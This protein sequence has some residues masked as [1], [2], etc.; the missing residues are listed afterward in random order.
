MAVGARKNIRGHRIGNRHRLDVCKAV[1]TIAG[2]LAL[3]GMDAFPA[4]AQKLVQ[5]RIT[6]PIRPAQM[7]VIH[8]TIHPMVAVA[9]DQGQMSGSTTI[10][11]MSLAFRL[12]AAQQADLKNLLLQQQTKGSPM[13]HRWLK[14]GQFAARYGMSASDLAKASAWIQSQGF[15]IDDIPASADRIDFSGTAAQ[16]DGA[17]HTQMHRYSLRGQTHWA[18]STEISLPQA[19]AG[20]ALGVRHLNSFRPLPHLSKRPVHVARQRAAASFNP[21]YTLCLSATS[22]CPSGDTANFIAPSDS[23]TIYDVTGLYNNNITGT[24]QT[25]AVVGQTDI[26]QYKSDIANFRTLSGLNASNLPTQILVT[27][28]PNN[29]STGPATVSVGDLEEADIDVEWSGAVAK[30]ATILYVTVGG[31]QSYS[32][33]DSLVYAVQNPL[34]NNDTQFVPVISISYGGCEQIDISQAY[35]QYFEGVLEQANAQGQTVVASSGDDGSATCDDTD[36]ANTAAS[37]GLAV[38]YPASSQYVTGVGGTSFS[39]DLGDQSAY[40][41][42][43]NNSD[44]GSA[45]GYIPESVWNNTPTLA[46]LSH[47]GQLSASGGGVSVIFSK[48]SWQVGSGVPGDGMRDVPDVALAADPNHDGFVLCTEEKNNAGTALT[49]MSSCV[50][51]VGSNQVPYFDANSDGYLYGGTSIAAPQIAAMITL[52][53]QEA[54]NTGGVGNANPILYLAAQNTPGAFHDV[55]TGSNAVVCKQGSPNCI[56]NG[57]GGYVMS[58]C[59]AGSGYDKATGLGSVDAAA[60]GVVWPAISTTTTNPTQPTFS[61]VPN[62]KTLSLTTGGSTNVTLVL[63]PNDGFTGTVAL[64]CSNLPANTTCSFAPSASATLAPDTAQNVTLTLNNSAS[65]RLVAPHPF[66]RNWPMQ[67]VF[68]GIFGLS[69]LGMGKKRRFPSRWASRWMTALLLAAGLMTATV[70]TA[71]GGGS[72][73]SS[74]GGGGTGPT[75]TTSTITVTGTS[76]NTSVADH[77][78]LTI[79]T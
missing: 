29:T 40:W 45:L 57:S 48:P 65:A 78:Q 47:A 77:I 66:H 53:N 41:N 22:P 5:N 16:V 75:S 3:I 63:T 58:C 8:G 54:G 52:W 18:N 2:V 74:G 23:Q 70:L 42:N 6:A 13:Y 10:Q 64:N 28:P 44:N 21:H 43:D 51:P 71:C 67:A 20:I 30:D 24:G 31:N 79:T 4:F 61:M 12:S 76:T 39:G 56:S 7:Q 32:V 49:G 26:E 55:T 25:M 69:L 60:M 33:F 50:Y 34:V 68:A 14:P 46:G 27:I 73:G 9:Q 11:G 35:I 59:N 37:K 15:K 62:S 38:D 17:F 36:S 1:V 72:A 19:I